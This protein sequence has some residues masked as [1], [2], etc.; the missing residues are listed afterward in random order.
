[1]STKVPHIIGVLEFY[2]KVIL[3]PFV[4]VNDKKYVVPYRKTKCGMIS[5][6]AL[7]IS[8]QLFTPVV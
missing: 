5:L 3:M 1:M 2:K 7:H 8:R 6:F 4:N